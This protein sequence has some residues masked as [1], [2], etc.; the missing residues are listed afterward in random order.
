MKNSAVSFRFPLRIG[1]MKMGLITSVLNKKL[2]RESLPYNEYLPGALRVMGKEKGLSERDLTIVYLIILLRCMS[3][4]QIYRLLYLPNNM[5]QR[6]CQ[7]RIQILIEKNILSRLDRR[8]GGLTQGSAFTVISPGSQTCRYINARHRYFKTASGGHL[9][10]HSLTVAEIFTQILEADIN[11]QLKLIRIQTEPACWRE[12][13]YF[14]HPAIKLK[15]DLYVVIKRNNITHKWFIEVD[16]GTLSKAKIQEKAWFYERYFLD[17]LE[18]HKTGILPKT[19]WITLDRDRAKYIL[20]CT[21]K[22][23]QF[24]PGLCDS[25]S[26]DKFLSKLTEIKSGLSK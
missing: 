1:E 13:R 6:A 25:V 7:I 2:H 14:V 8:L 5:T 15:P 12:Y 9:I 19:L 16:R 18:Q 20:S 3:I 23:D 11:K 10:M 17:S 21:S 26:I 22:T 4:G 24:V